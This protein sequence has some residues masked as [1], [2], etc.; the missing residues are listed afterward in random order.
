MAAVN[1]VS[2]LC[3]VYMIGVV[4]YSAAP[5]VKASGR[6]ER[7]KLLNGFKKGKAALIYFAALP[8]YLLAHAYNGE[9][10]AGTLWLAIKSCVDTFILK[11]DYT[12][13]AALMADNVF[14]AAVD[15]I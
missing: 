8:L 14:Y 11:F 7:L 10:A 15:E 9:S 4:V 12:S 13:A 6:E 5:F 1:I 2:V 3:L